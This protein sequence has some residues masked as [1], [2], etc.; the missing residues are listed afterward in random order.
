MTLIGFAHQP[1][2]NAS[3][4]HRAHIR[5]STTTFSFVSFDNNHQHSDDDNYDETSDTI[6]EVIINNMD[7]NSN[8]EINETSKTERKKGVKH[9]KFSDN[10]KQ[11]ILDVICCHV[12]MLVRL[13]IY[14]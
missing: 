8:N 3:L 1:N 6:E 13:Y 10:E 7:D 5:Q 12:L 11:H 9:M 2:D 4:S 14:S